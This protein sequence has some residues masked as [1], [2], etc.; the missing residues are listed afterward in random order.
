MKLIKIV[1]EVNKRLKIEINNEDPIALALTGSRAG[2]Y[3]HKKKGYCH[4]SDFDFFAIFESDIPFYYYDFYLDNQE[5]SIKIEG[6]NR[7]EKKIKNPLKS[8]AEQRNFVCLPYKPFIG[9]NYLKN[10][11]RAARLFLLEDFIS[12]L[13]YN[14]LVK[15]L[16]ERIAEYPLIKEVLI[17]PSAI[18]RLKMISNSKINPLKQ[19][20]KKYIES[21]EEKGCAPSRDGSYFLMNQTVHKKNKNTFMKKT[22]LDAFRYLKKQTNLSA[23]KYL[24]GGLFILSQLPEVISNHF[25]SFPQFEQKNKHLIYTGPKLVDYVNKK[26]CSSLFNSLRFQTKKIKEYL[27][28]N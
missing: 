10:I 18:T 17:W 21:L 9:E 27:L 2:G 3:P 13:P 4:K 1:E 22:Q 24:F 15:V 11:E 20:T 16:P 5:I 26:E 7:F 12:I 19:I 8:F 25:Y 23:K 6:K 28:F 14:S